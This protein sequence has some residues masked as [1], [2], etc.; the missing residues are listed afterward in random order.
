MTRPPH[1]L[2]PL[3]GLGFERA[4]HRRGDAEWLEQA[5]QQARVLQITARSSAAMRDGGLYFAPSEDVPTDA[6]RRFL[7]E[8]DGLPYFSCT[9]EMGAEDAGEWASLRDLGSGVDDLHG[10]MFAAAIGLEQW[11]QRHRRCPLC[12]EATTETEAGWTRTCPADGST[13]FPRTDP[14]VIMMVT[15]GDRCLLGRAASWPDGRFSTLAGFVEPG[16]SLEA[17]VAREVAEECGVRV[18]DI[19]YLASQP[20]PFPS[21]L[22]L[23]FSARLVGSEE[24]TVDAAELSDAAWFTRDEVQRAA[25]RTDSD[26][27]PDPSDLLQYVS[28]SLSISR[29]LVDEWLAGRFA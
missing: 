13:H 14:A 3:G 27:S 2:P 8:V 17:A 5:W 25:A 4:G 19:T 9:V 24:L 29:W 18:G 20:W 28:P 1:S 21:S 6:V 23:G 7:G 22:M 11:H 26:A 16:E 12:G 15:D 10:G